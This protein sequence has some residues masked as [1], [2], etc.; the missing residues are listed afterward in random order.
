MLSAWTRKAP[1]LEPSDTKT[2]L[3]YLKA[4]DTLYVDSIIEGSGLNAQTVLKLMLEL[5]LRGL[6]TQH[7]GKLL[8]LG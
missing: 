3:N 2:I 7:L 6:V 1:G 4:A 5:E 8:S